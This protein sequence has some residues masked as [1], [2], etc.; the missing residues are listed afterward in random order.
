L[1]VVKTYFWAVGWRFRDFQKLIR[2]SHYYS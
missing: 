1:S 2:V